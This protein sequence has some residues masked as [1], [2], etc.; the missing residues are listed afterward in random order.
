[1]DKIRGVMNELERLRDENINLKTKNMQL[2]ENIARFKKEVKKIKLILLAV[3]KAVNQYQ[4][5]GDEPETL[6]I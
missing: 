2:K 3:S 6:D 1:M 5:L 4:H